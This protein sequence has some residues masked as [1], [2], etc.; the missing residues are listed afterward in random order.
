MDWE[1]KVEAPTFVCAA[2][3]TPI[4]PGAAF[5]SALLFQ[6][7]RFARLD[8]G[9]EQWP[10]QD[11]ARFLSWWRQKAPD[12]SGNGPQT[13]DVEA[14]KR[15]FHALK[16]AHERPKQCFVWIVL[17]FLVRARKL[18]FKESKHEGDRSFLLVEDKEN[19]C[20]Y[21]VR[22]PGMTPAE[23]QQVQANLLEIM[24]GRPPADAAPS[25]SPTPDA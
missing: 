25:A 3:N 24:E 10:A 23:A 1:G 12:A 11:Q 18:R 16:D 21:R 4:A 8:Y 9:A 2:T 5:F 6:D 20:F 7:G 22:D 19:R 14:L 17:L 15:M 13:L